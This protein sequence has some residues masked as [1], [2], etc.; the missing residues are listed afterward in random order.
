MFSSRIPIN[1]SSNRI[2]QALDRLRAAGAPLVDLTESNPTRVGLCYPPDALQPLADAAGLVYEPQPFGLLAA[3]RAVAAALLRRG[4]SA[5]AE[6]LILTASTSEAYSLLFKLLCDPGDHIL[7]PRPSYPLFE[8]LTRLD[9]VA[10]MP[11]AL[12]YDGRWRI[13]L[14]GLSRAVGPRARAVLLVNPNN[15]TGSFV[16]REELDAV[17]AMCRDRSLALIGDEV[18]NRYP[19]E[20]DAADVPSVLDQKEALTFSLGGLSK[21]AGLPQLKL[22]WT[23]VDGPEGLV[24]EAL[25]R[26]ELICDT[27]LS[28]STPVQHAVPALLAVG[29]TVAAQIA[30]RIRANYRTLQRL[31][32]DHAASRVLHA[33]GGW[34]A[35]IQVPATRS[36]ETLVLELLERD[37]VLVHPGYFFDF[38]REAFLVVSLLPDPDLLRQGVRRVLDR[39]EH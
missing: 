1:L 6:R 34:Y 35:V 17:V 23:V 22:G 8:H 5:D 38:P 11:Y 31:A 4:V 19:L 28:V 21:A 29:E 14:D 32:A 33:E 27:Y 10:P 24:D 36:E 26:L 13:D 16:T 9:G 7:V 20:A 12:E 2:T 15:P 37:H 25:A 30:E 18:F 39:A 3:R